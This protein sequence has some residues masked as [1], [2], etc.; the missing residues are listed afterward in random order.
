MDHAVEDAGGTATLF[1]LCARVVNA[2]M[3][4]LEQDV[5]GLPAVV[6]QGILPL[7]NIYYLERIEQA[8]VKKGLSTQ[9]I[10]C[11][12][13]N[14]VMKS[15]PSRFG[16]V[17]CWRKKF[18]E[19]F[20][21]N[22]LR[23]I[24]NVSSDERLNDQ[25]FSPLVHSARHVSELTICNKQQGVS[26]LT[27]AVLE[28]L[29]R[30]VES[31]KFLHLRSSDQA[32]QRSLR[33][34]LHRLI[35]HG[36]VKRVSLLSWPSPDIN[37]LV[38][39]LSISAGFW[40][41]QTSCPCTFC[42]KKTLNDNSQVLQEKRPEKGLLQS[43][44]SADLSHMHS[45]HNV[46]EDMGSQSALLSL[47]PLNIS[48]SVVTDCSDCSSAET[49][50]RRVPGS[51][52]CKKATCQKS[53][54]PTNTVGSKAA[55]TS[56]K[57]LI[58][59]SDI[60]G[61]IRTEPD[62]LYDFIFSVPSM[63]EGGVLNMN[64]GYKES[65][66]EKPSEVSTVP[67]FDD[68]PPVEERSIIS[69]FPDGAHRFRS[70]RA[71]N[72]HNVPLTLS[73]CRFL[74]HLLRSWVSLERLTMAY[75]DLGANI[76]LIVEAL[77]A[78]SRCPGCSLSMFSMSDFTTYVP[79]LD[80][81]NTILTTFPSL[82]LLSL[83]YDL[84]NHNEKETSED[85]P[86]EF[87]ENQLKQLEI[88]FPQ[89]PLPVGSLISVLKASTL[90]LELSLD[91]ATFSCTEDLKCVLHTLAEHN[92]A[93]RRLSFH[94]MKMTDMH[95]EIVLLLN[96]SSLEE[97]KFSFCRLFER[98]T[99]EFLSAFV[100]A[101]RKNPSVKILKLCGNRLG[102]DGLTALADLYNPDSL[103]SIHYLDVSSNCIKPE[104]LLHFAKKLERCGK[105]KLKHLSI[106]QNLLD[107]D[108]VMA[109]EALQS[110]EGV[111]CVVS[112]NWDSAQAF[113]DHVSVM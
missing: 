50:P 108:P 49:L 2:N 43:S 12:L 33:L 16:T 54:L 19:A 87:K 106:S 96:S 92:K 66:K 85:I 105:I 7:L 95:S 73:S 57:N 42:L 51:T 100:D 88:R 83:S 23:G 61:S 40:Q 26:E 81:A 56:R 8:A 41:K 90:L 36:Q 44:S 13:W 37:L 75:N 80:L 68:L 97:I 78:L 34:L 35:H 110:L 30:S 24:L 31:L 32:T 72:L 82:Q 59:G 93:L 20:F 99:E 111:C 101:L 46:E 10:W 69:Q 62:D 107:R 14:D 21:H 63:G 17:T 47:Q 6:L 65:A 4:K 53:S 9:S 98:G 71:L 76:F 5:W 113:A 11:K 52:H 89:D 94:D 58:S 91:N 3:E 109:Q 48:H 86:A 104:G 103:C 60:Q 27:P 77:S 84:E 15:K 70:V 38:L 22:V 64:Q 1:E 102:N 45:K 28:C 18:L 55:S 39:I 79:T 25:R 29:A 74:C 67:L 112:D